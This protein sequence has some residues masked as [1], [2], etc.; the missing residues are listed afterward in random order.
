MSQPQLYLRIHNMRMLLLFSLLCCVLII[1]VY[2][3]QSGV[4][5]FSDTPELITSQYILPE[6]PIVKYKLDRQLQ[7]LNRPITKYKLPLPL[8]NVSVPDNRP[9]EIETELRFLSKIKPDSKVAP[10]YE[11]DGVLPTFIKYAGEQSLIYDEQHLIDVARDTETIV[12]RM[13]NLYARPRPYLVAPWYKIK[14]QHQPIWNNGP[15]YPCLPVLQARMLAFVL[16][17]NNPTHQPA[18]FRLVKQIELSRL[19]GGYN[20]PSDIKA[21][22]EIANI[23]KKHVEYLEPDV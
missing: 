23:L 13:Q 9:V 5:K 12:M 19:A 14:L 21:S 10:K 4:E 15:C 8:S 1:N 3:R 22:V 20:Y 7:K 17:Y 11:Q 2:F 16:S 6:L 18:L